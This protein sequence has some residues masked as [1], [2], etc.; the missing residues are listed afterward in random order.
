MKSNLQKLED[1]LEI[2]ESKV[3]AKQSI[4]LLGRAIRYLSYR[5]HSETELIKK[6]RPHAQSE[7]ELSITL[8]KLKEKQFLSN[9]R[10]AESLVTK[11][12]RNLGSARLAQEMRQHQLDQPIIEKQLQELK[13][14]EKQRAFEVWE[15]KFGVIATEQ[16]DLAKQ[17]RF[18]VSR[19]FDQE[20]V[21]KIVRGKYPDE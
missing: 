18:L 11:K 10:F 4:S 19:G 7:E 20:L 15:K 12:S 2:I 1:Q 9:E 16:K 13:L 17:I 3:P 5:E 8:Q 14:T 6:L 21:Y